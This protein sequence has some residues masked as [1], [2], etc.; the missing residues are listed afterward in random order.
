VTP[1]VKVETPRAPFSSATGAAHVHG[2]V[3][4]HG[5]RPAQSQTATVATAQARASTNAGDASVQKH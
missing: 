5:T 4:F 1:L 2:P 3:R